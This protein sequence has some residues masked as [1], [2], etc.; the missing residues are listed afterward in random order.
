MRP[1]HAV[2]VSRGCS[3][4]RLLNRKE[5][6]V[7]KEQRK[8]DLLNNVAPSWR[9][10]RPL[11]FNYASLRGQLDGV[12][13]SRML[14]TERQFRPVPDT[15]SAFSRRAASLDRPIPSGA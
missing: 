10:L 12:A 1:P 11:R 5:R 2:I 8:E 4:T 7:R 15:P 14:H 3:H 9:S 6:E 13:I